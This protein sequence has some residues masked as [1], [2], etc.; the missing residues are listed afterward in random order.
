M[1]LCFANSVYLQLCSYIE[2]NHPYGLAQE[3][4]QKMKP[5]KRGQMPPE[6]MQYWGMH[7]TYEYRSYTANKAK[8]IS[9]RRFQFYPD[10]GPN[11]RAKKSTS[12]TKRLSTITPSIVRLSVPESVALLSSSAEKSTAFL[13]KSLPIRTIPFH[14]QSSKRPLSRRAAIFAKHKSSNASS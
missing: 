6:L 2:E 8:G 10:L 4:Q 13:A 3:Q 12:V 9:S 7:D 1:L 14:G 5:Q 11:V